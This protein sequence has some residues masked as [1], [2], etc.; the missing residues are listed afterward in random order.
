MSDAHPLNRLLTW[1]SSAWWAEQRPQ[2]YSKRW[3][4]A[5]PGKNVVW[6]AQVWRH[7][8]EWQVHAQCRSAWREQA[9]AVSDCVFAAS[10]GV[11]LTHSCI[12]P[13]NQYPG[14]RLRKLLRCLHAVENRTDVSI[15]LCG[16]SSLILG[17]LAGV[18][19]VGAALE[20]YAMLGKELYFHIGM[21]SWM[22][23]GHVPRQVNS[24]A[25]AAACKAKSLSC[26]QWCVDVDVWLRSSVVDSTFMIAFDGA[27][28]DNPGPSG[29]G[30]C[31]HAASGEL[32]AWWAVPLGHGSNN[33]A[34]WEA[35]VLA[36]RVSSMLI[37]ARCDKSWETVEASVH[38]F[39]DA[40]SYESVRLA[41]VL[42]AS[43]T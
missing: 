20:Y 18:N 16:D 17:Q 31:V 35:C 12:A 4:H 32:W 13:V 1:R 9:M 36:L 11:P 43:L 24:C 28:T 14:S 37:A 25:D 5:R 15:Y 40:E 27:A 6:E 22:K 41:F 26:S 19:S 38:D 23:I 30:V 39:I 3:T 42:G 33:R 29:A 34:E 21:R 8:K 2:R 10:L 7:D